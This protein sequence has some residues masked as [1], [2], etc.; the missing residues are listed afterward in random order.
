MIR[1]SPPIIWIVDDEECFCMSTQECLT[2][3]YNTKYFLDTES[4]AKALE[5][6]CPDLLILD[7][8]FNRDEQVGVKFL[9]R[10]R[11]QHQFLPVLICTGL[12][13]ED[14][15]FLCGKY[16][17]TGYIR[18]AVDGFIQQVHQSVEA[19]LKA[20][21][22]N[23]SIAMVLNDK[24]VFR[25]ITQKDLAECS[26]VSQRIIREYLENIGEIGPSVSKLAEMTGYS[27]GTLNNHFKQDFNQSVGSLLTYIAVVLGCRLRAYGYTVS[28]AASTVGMHPERFRRRVVEEFNKPPSEISRADIEYLLQVDVLTSCQQMS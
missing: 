4:L 9:K 14:A 17:A 24:D 6:E 16:N 11:E 8:M 22:L 12:R 5:T 7:L 10:F 27:I 21:V 28:E 20:H 23:E 3:K 13:N 2:P 18:K 26:N 25:T 1:C 19:A 15:S